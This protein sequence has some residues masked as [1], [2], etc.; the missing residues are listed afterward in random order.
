MPT[1]VLY[2]LKMWAGNHDQ[3]LEIANNPNVKPLEMFS[4]NLSKSSKLLIVGLE[5]KDLNGQELKELKNSINRLK[6]PVVDV[7]LAIV[8]SFEKLMLFCQE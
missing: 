1:D 6:E 2:Y 4:E 5:G 7:E 3:F 8:E